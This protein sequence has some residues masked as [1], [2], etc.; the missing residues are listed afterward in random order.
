MS[1][2]VWFI[3]RYVYH[4][5]PLITFFPGS[6][7][8]ILDFSMLQGRRKDVEFLPSEWNCGVS[9]FPDR[10]TSCSLGSFQM[11]DGLYITVH[12]SVYNLVVLQFSVQCQIWHPSKDYRISDAT[13]KTASDYLRQQGSNISSCYV[14]G[15]ILPI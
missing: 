12:T 6:S 3:R 15:H 1:T 4:A 2:L 13:E 10:I 7:F 9:C 8:L 11:R 14:D 5:P